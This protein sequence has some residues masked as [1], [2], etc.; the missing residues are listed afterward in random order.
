MN[1]INLGACKLRYTYYSL[2]GLTLSSDHIGVLSL[3]MNVADAK[4][5]K[6]VL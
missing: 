1:S 5:W 3:S 2:E 4:T 6:K